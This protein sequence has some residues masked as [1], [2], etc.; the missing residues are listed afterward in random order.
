MAQNL[1]G[2]RLPKDGAIRAK[3]SSASP[4]ERYRYAIRRAEPWSSAGS[5]LGAFFDLTERVSH[6]KSVS[7]VKC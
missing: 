3:G 6:Y 2:A 4:T 1:G 7:L 5:R